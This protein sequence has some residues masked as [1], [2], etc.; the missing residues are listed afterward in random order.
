[1]WSERNYRSKTMQFSTL[2][3]PLS[4]SRV[5]SRACFISS[6]FSFQFSVLFL[7]H[8]DRFVLI[9][10][11]QSDSSPLLIFELPLSV[12]IALT[13]QHISRLWLDLI[14]DVECCNFSGA[15][16]RS[17]AR[18]PEGKYTLPATAYPCLI[19]VRSLEL[20]FAHRKSCRLFLVEIHAPGLFRSVSLALWCKL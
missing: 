5:I 1:M 13:L 17:W 19:T 9:I 3:A 4:I 6:Q 11:S 10:K 2:K 12:S 18:L 16:E 7:L 8:P 15:K 14:V 20:R